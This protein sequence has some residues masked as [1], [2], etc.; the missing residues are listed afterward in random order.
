MQNANVHIMNAQFAHFV[1]DLTSD[2]LAALLMPAERGLAGSVG[3]LPVPR[4]RSGRLRLFW[5]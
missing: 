3:R 1:I 2:R 4:P 5:R